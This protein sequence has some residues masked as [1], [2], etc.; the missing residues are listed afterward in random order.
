MGV[1]LTKFASPVGAP[2][3]KCSP[4][5]V[6]VLYGG[7]GATRYRISSP[8]RGK[9]SRCFCS[10]GRHIGVLSNQNFKLDLTKVPISPFSVPLRPE[11]CFMCTA[12]PRPELG[13]P[14]QLCWNARQHFHEPC[15]DP[16]SRIMPHALNFATPLAKNQDRVPCTAMCTSAYVRA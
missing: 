13:A 14:I 11:W 12:P 7:R 3:A 4:L 2:S 1:P 15:S 8:Y 16:S 10:C 5:G 9:S 6:Q